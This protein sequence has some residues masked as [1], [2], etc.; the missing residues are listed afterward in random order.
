MSTFGITGVTGTLIESVSASEKA[1]I[2]VIH[3]NDGTF[4][5]AQAYD[6][7]QSFSVKGRGDTLH[8]PGASSSGNPTGITGIVIITNSKQSSSNTEFQSF[9]YSGEAYPTAS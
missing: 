9:E 5:A 2:S 4:G 8:M 7:K 1:D 6:R 3:N